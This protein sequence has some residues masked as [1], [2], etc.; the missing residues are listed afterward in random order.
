MNDQKTQQSQAFTD[1]DT[2][3][4]LLWRSQNV[5]LTEIARR[6]NRERRQVESK[7]NGLQLREKEPVRGDPWEAAS[8][9]NAVNGS[10]LLL[11]RLV[12]FH[13]RHHPRSDVARIKA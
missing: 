1:E 11:R 7:Y 5:G 9:A 13:R 6:L 8:H 4:L 2:R 3:L 12:Q 10:R